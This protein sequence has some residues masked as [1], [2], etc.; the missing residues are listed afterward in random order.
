VTELVL[1]IDVGGEEFLFMVYTG[2]MVSL[3]Q[4]GISKAQARPCDLQARGVTGT[5]L[6][7][8]SEQ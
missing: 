6:D 2:A 7:V 1:T 4:S 5:H 3:I 8:L